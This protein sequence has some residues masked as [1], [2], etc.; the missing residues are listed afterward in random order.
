MCVAKLWMKD[1]STLVSS[2]AQK[3]RVIVDDNSHVLAKNYELPSG[4]RFSVPKSNTVRFCRS[5][6]SFLNT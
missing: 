6:S 1:K 3:A 5:R 2:V 4:R